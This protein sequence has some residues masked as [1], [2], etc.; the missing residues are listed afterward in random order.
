M[1]R[2][3]CFDTETTGFDFA[4]GD[5]IIEI[6][7]VEVVDG[8]ITANTFH[9]YINPERRPI[10]AAAY[11]VHKISNTFLADKPLFPAVA[12]RFLDF[13]G[14]DLIV[15]HNGKGFDFPFMNFQLEAAGLPQIPTAQQEDSMIMAQRKIS[16]LKSYSL[17][18]LAKYF[19]ISLESRSDAHGALIDTYIL[20]RVYLELTRRADKKTVLEIADAQHRDFLAA[21]KS[22]GT[23]PHRTFSPSAAEIEAHKKW[24]AATIKNPIWD[25]A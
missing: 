6:G 7:A 4:I 13:A 23:F 18:A 1:T 16:E 12:K 11:N 3:V 5:K 2:I 14:N 21:P 8:E 19:N 15:A 22:D 9:E 20:A 24:I 17:D 10:S 25:A